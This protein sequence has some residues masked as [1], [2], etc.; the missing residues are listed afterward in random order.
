MVE[1]INFTQTVITSL[2]PPLNSR[3]Y[4]HDKEVNG[5]C[6]CV[7]PMGGKTFYSYKKISGRPERIRIGKFPELSVKKARGIASDINSAIE[8]GE[9]P[10]DVMREEKAEMTFGTMFKEYMERHAKPKK[11]SWQG[12]E[13]QYR[14][15]LKK[16]FSG[17]KL[18][19]ITRKDIAKLHH[20]IGKNSG[21]YAANRA[22]ALIRCVYNRAIEWG[23]Y[24]SN[25]CEKIKMYKERSR[26]RFLQPGEMNRFFEAL[27]K[28]PNEVIRD[29]VLIS[30]F[31]GQRKTNVLTMKW[32]DIDLQNAVWRIPAGQTKNETV[33]NVPL[34]PQVMD[35]LR[36]R[37]KNE[38]NQGK[39]CEYVLPARNRL[40]G[41]HHKNTHLV[42]PR[43]G[44]ERILKA[45]NLRDVR[46]HD[47]RRTMGSYMS[48]GGAS[49]TIVGKALGH[50]SQQSTQVYARLNID[51][52]RAAMEKA[53]SDMLK[54]A[55]NTESDKIVRI[56]DV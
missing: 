47:L 33:Q 44:L 38:L 23:V 4:Y 26:D 29:F 25:P 21:H 37:R 8:R 54:A 6:V 46:L 41:L 7:T 13:K 48:I 9:N 15:Y 42:E 49:M 35:T 17:K 32:A 16:P 24:E 5:L 31:T 1:K 2:P 20:E 10:A 53:A 30:L 12:D 14:T 28:E 51:P 50:M 45:A 40:K 43:K 18:S 36:R 55:I 27:A 56:D 19:N 52:V 39:I 22:L 3:K 11:K 34:V